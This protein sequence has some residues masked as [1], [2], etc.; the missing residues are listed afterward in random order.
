MVTKDF[1]LRHTK[2]GHTSLTLNALGRQLL[3]SLVRLLGLGPP[4][5]DAAGSFIASDSAA[6]NEAELESPGQ[7]V[8]DVWLLNIKLE[9][10]ACIVIQQDAAL[11]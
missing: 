8:V 11:L 7:V 6:G 2:P 5:A 1:T 3:L 9:T 4:A 10:L